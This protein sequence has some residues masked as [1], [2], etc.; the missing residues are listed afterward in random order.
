M[1][2]KSSILSGQHVSTFIGSSSGPLRNRSK[3]YLY[4]SALRDPI[5]AWRWPN[6]ARNTSP[7]QYTTFIVH[8]FKLLCYWLT[9][10]YLCLP[11]YPATWRQITINDVGFD[12]GIQDRV[13][14]VITVT[15]WIK[16]PPPPT[17]PKKIWCQWI[18][19]TN[20]VIPQPLLETYTHIAVKTTIR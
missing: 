8:R 6:K 15:N 3:S 16:V 7:W 18:N 14:I 12:L 4:F 20:T 5:W 17:L 13:R 1:C 2:N 11:T 9:R 10:L 19:K